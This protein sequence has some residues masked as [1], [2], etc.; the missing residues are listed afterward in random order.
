MPTGLLQDLSSCTCHPASGTLGLG[1]APYAGVGVP[2]SPLLSAPS[3]ASPGETI[4]GRPLFFLLTGPNSTPAYPTCDRCLERDPW[5]PPILGVVSNPGGDPASPSGEVEADTGNPNTGSLGVPWR[6]T[7]ALGP[8]DIP[9]LGKS[10]LA[11]LEPSL[12]QV[13]WC[14]HKRH[15]EVLTSSTSQCDCLEMESLQI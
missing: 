11:S 6:E 1:T 12:L 5:V 10:F 13:G 8:T 4:S 14:P 2:S 15:A 9:A 3:V 7:E